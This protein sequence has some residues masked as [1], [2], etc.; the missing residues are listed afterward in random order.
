M[1]TLANHCGKS[2]GISTCQQKSRFLL[3]EHVSMVSLL[4][5]PFSVERYLKIRFTLFCGN[6]AENI[7]H[8]FLSCDF[9]SLVWNLWLE[10]PPRIQ[11]F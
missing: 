3:G 11:G 1:G 4:W 9:S 7:D 6:E 10:N 8:A 5:M 2:F